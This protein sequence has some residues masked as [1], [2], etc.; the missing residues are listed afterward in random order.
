[1]TMWFYFKLYSLTLLAFLIVDLM[2]LGFFA[3]GFYRKYLGFLLRPNPNW[4]AAILFYLIF[5]AG[6]LVFCVLPARQAASA[7]RAVLLGALFGF[8]AYATYDMTNL[9]TV[10]KWP[11][12]VTVVDMVWGSVLSGT[13]AAVSYWISRWV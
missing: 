3:R 10:K 8:I 2:W 6:I 11:V 12:L 13:V 5:I 1:M 4:A 7:G 9:A